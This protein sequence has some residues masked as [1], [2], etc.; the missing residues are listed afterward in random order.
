MKQTTYKVP[1]MSCEHC[2]RAISLSLEDLD[3]IKNVDIDLSAKTVKIEFDETK[4]EEENLKEAIEDAG[5]D[6]E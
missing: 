4:V 5:Y 3:G 1:G 6:I 2:K